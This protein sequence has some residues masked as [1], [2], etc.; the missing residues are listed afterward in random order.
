MRCFNLALTLIAVAEE[1][2]QGASI[3]YVGNASSTLAARLPAAQ[4]QTSL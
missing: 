2:L 4:L 1:L 3:P